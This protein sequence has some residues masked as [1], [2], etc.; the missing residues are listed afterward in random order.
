M[1]AW[2][3]AQ[4]VASTAFGCPVCDSGTGEQV[5]AALFDEDFGRT[6]IAVLLPFPILLAVVAMIH[7]GWPVRRRRP[8]PPGRHEI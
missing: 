2:T 1:I 8:E 3:A 6:L 4:A 5:R 7:F